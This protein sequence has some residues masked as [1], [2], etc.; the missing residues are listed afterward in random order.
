MV[1]FNDGKIPR[2]IAQFNVET[3]FQKADL[4]VRCLW[5]LEQQIRLGGKGI[6]DED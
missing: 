3:R 4:M 5:N 6:C 1:S 2:A